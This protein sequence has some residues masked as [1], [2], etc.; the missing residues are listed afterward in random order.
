MDEFQ[1]QH[2]AF[3]CLERKEKENQKTE[4]GIEKSLNDTITM[5]SLFGD[6]GVYD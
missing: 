5:M 4:N 1:V 6:S 2:K 3:I